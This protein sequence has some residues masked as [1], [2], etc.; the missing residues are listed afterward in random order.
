MEQWIHEKL[1]LKSLP[2]Y[3]LRKCFE[4]L[5]TKSVFLQDYEILC[6]GYHNNTKQYARLKILAS[7]STSK[8]LQGPHEII[9]YNTNQYP[10][11]F[12]VWSL[13][14]LRKKFLKFTDRLSFERSAFLILPDQKVLLRLKC[15]RS[16]ITTLRKHP[17]QIQKIP[18]FENLFHSL[19]PESNLVS[20]NM[21]PVIKQPQGVCIRAELQQQHFLEQSFTSYLR[22]Y[23]NTSMTKTMI[24]QQ[25]KKDIMNKLDVLQNYYEKGGVDKKLEIKEEI[26]VLKEE[27]MET[28][29]NRDEGEQG[30]EDIFLHDIDFT[31]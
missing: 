22:G 11:H 6:I 20:M 25:F 14:T 28:Y 5:N 21:N 17:F 16:I 31:Y 15:I 3:S 13:T 26:E 30:E 1:K 4:Y 2:N 10:I 9:I 23:E 8:T 24:F 18:I 19:P 12:W 27:E 7:T 29:Q